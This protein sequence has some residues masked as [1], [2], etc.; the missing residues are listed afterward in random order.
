MA[1]RTKSEKFIVEEIHRSVINFAD[2]NPRTISKTNRNRLKKSLVEN[3]LVEPLVWN[4]RTGRLVSGHQRLAIIDETEKTQD[5]T[6]SVAVIDV[7]ELEEKQ[8]N[9]RL[10]NPGLMGDFDLELLQ[11]LHLDTG[12]AFQDFGFTD[13]DVNMLLGEKAAATAKQ[14]DAPVVE[15]AKN[16]L[17]EVKENREEMSERF[18][19]IGRNESSFY[20]TIV[21]HSDG[22]K[23]KFLERLGVPPY[24]T[25]VPIDVLLP[26]IKEFVP[27]IDVE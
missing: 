15:A 26:H 16:T 8:I 24:E 5:Y 21:C 11:S 14:A 2:Y 3:G 19:R 22:E 20:V 23:E 17:A 27:I 7:D 12:I 13:F 25:Y 6:L 4:R 1:K 18:E 9:V 10:N